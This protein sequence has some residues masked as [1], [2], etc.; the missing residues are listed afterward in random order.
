MNKQ[1]RD[2][3]TVSEHVWYYEVGRKLI[4]VVESG[5]L[6]RRTSVDTVQFSVPLSMLE[7]TL[8]RS[9]RKGKR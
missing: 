7:A 1:S 2:P 9:P 3:Q 4:F 5:Y 6:E 8:A